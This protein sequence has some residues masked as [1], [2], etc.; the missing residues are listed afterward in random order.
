M[1]VWGSGFHF[2]AQ[3]D[4]SLTV[5]PA[6]AELLL[7]DRKAIIAHCRW[8]AEFEELAK[9]KRGAIISWR[10]QKEVRLIT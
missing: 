3:G 10:A 6:L 9:R 8:H 1:R 7:F 5:Q 4:Y 2:S